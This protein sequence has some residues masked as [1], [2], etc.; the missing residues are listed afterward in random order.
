MQKFDNKFTYT[1]Y[2]PF[3]ETNNTKIFKKVNV[4]SKFNRMNS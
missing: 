3:Q 1:D 4:K 2:T